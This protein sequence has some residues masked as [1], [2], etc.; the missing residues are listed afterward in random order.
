MSMTPLLDNKVKPQSGFKI[1]KGN[2]RYKSRIY[3]F[4]QKNSFQFRDAF[5]M[6]PGAHSRIGKCNGVENCT[7]PWKS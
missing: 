5:E 4:S 2:P 7:G 6:Q 1:S 3:N